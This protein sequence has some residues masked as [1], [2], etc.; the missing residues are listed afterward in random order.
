MF[1][2]LL[3]VEYRG[4]TP[5]SILIGRR[6]GDDAGEIAPE[7]DESECAEIEEALDGELF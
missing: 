4:A 5:G 3:L 2:P 7:K 6:L 1:M